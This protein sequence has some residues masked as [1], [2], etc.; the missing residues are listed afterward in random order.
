MHII[1]L[2]TG[3]PM[4]MKILAI[5]RGNPTLTK[6][7]SI[8]LGMIP[9]FADFIRLRVSWAGWRFVVGCSTADEKKQRANACCN[10]QLEK[11]SGS[12]THYSR[13]CFSMLI[14]LCRRNPA[15]HCSIHSWRF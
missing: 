8:S 1:D 3:R 4:T 15:S 11:R 12:F 9:L 5:P 2:A 6:P 14:S 13:K 10:V 7:D